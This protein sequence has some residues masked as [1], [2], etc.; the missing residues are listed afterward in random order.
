M[1]RLV[2][3]DFAK[4]E[5]FLHQYSLAE[6]LESKTRTQ[7]LKRGHKFSLAALQIWAGAVQLSNADLLLAG[8]MKI[9][10]NSGH[11]AQLEEC[12]SDLTSAYFA[13]LH[14]L[15]KPAYMSLR[16]AIET[17]VRA[18]AGAHSAEA[19]NTTSVHR[20]FDLAR[21]T[22]VFGGPSAAPFESLHQKYSD[23]CAHVHSG[24][25]AHLMRNHA[26]S[27]F[28]KQDIERLRAWIITS[29]SI[30]KS[31]LAILIYSNRALYFKASPS[32]QDVYDETVPKEARLFAIG[33]P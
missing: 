6:I 14:G 11:F 24:Q 25:L 12:F 28:P 32:V 27:N 13:A 22:D 8:K 15:Y 2:E 3:K 19:A 18:L 29:E 20:L 16:S 23:L 33:A 5:E 10:K 9:D 1:A 31:I 17:F 7:L 30:T 21:T 4:L 26:M